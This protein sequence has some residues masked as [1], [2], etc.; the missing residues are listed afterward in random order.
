[1]SILRAGVN[2]KLTLLILFQVAS[3]VEIGLT[4]IEEWSD[5]GRHDDLELARKVLT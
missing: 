5:V 1:M 3:N 2:R 4:P